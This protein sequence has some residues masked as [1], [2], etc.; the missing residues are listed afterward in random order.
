MAEPKE[1]PQ[2]N[3]RW[4]GEGDIAPL[5][6]HRDGDENISCWHLSMEERLHLL[7]TGEVW[8]HVWGRHP[9]VCVS[10]ESPFTVDNVASVAPAN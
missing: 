4:V 3:V 6:A 7:E 8:L 9:A 10:A 5:P 1:F 2:A